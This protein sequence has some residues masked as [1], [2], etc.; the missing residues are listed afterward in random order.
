VP[1]LCNLLGDEEFGQ[2]AADTLLKL[3]GPD[4]VNELARV[5]DKGAMAA[6]IPAVRIL[7][8][9]GPDAKAAYSTLYQAA[10]TYRGKPLGKE[11][12]DAMKAIQ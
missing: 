8:K 10:R 11:A 12:M 1:D 6:K 4:V 9:M 3:G 7:G 2:L 5:V